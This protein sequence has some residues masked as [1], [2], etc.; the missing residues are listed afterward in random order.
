MWKVDARFPQQVQIDVDN[1]QTEEAFGR[2]W[3]N[4]RQV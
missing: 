2:D 1:L 4:N 3:N